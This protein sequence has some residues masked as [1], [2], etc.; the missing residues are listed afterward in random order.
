MRKLAKKIKND[1]KIAVNKRNVSFALEMA[2]MALTLFGGFLSFK[3]E[4][5]DKV[6]IN[7]FGVAGV[8]LQGTTTAK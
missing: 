7:E 1:L 3:G 2:Q 6:S 8:I 5:K 4:I